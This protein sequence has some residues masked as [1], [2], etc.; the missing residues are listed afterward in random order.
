MG[1]NRIKACRK[2]SKNVSKLGQKCLKIGQNH[3]KMERKAPNTESTKI[4]PQN[5]IFCPKIS[6]FHPKTPLLLAMQAFWIETGT[7]THRKSGKNGSKLGKI[8][9]KWVAIPQ[10][11]THPKILIF[12]LKSP[13]FPPILT[14][15]SPFFPPF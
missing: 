1:G 4:L 3:L 10:H 2:S 13:F 14:P 12:T 5:R 6:L 8:I 9:S 15:K 7:K 11:Q